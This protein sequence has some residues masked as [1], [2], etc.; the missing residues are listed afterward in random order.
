MSKTGAVD[1]GIKGKRNSAERFSFLGFALFLGITVT[2]WML[3]AQVFGYVV[4]YHRELGSGLLRVGAHTV[5]FPWSW[6]V[7]SFSWSQAEGRLG[8]YVLWLNLGGIISIA[9]GLAAGYFFYYKRSLR[10]E[11]V[12]DLHGSARF[13]TDEDVYAMGLVPKEGTAARGVFVGAFKFLRDGVIRFL[14]YVGD[15]HLLCYAPTRSGKGVTLIIP[16]LL[17]YVHS[18]FTN[19]VKLE[20]FELTSGFRHR[21]GSLVIRFEPTHMPGTSVD[22]TTQGFNTARWNVLDE[23]RIWTPYDVMDAQN[24]AAAIADPDAKGM[25]DHW[26]STSYELLTGLFLHMKYAERNKSLAGCAVYLADPLF[27]TPE[28]MF[29]RMINAEHDPEGRMGWTDSTGRPTKTHPVVA[30]AAQAML[31]KEEKERNSVLST[32]KTRLALFMEPIVGFN[33]SHSDFCINDLMNHEKPVSLYLGVPPSDKERLR[34]LIRLFI[35]FLLR[36]LTADMRFEDG[37]SAAS[38]LNPLLLML[39][40]LSSLRKLDALQDA[41]AYMAGYG[42]RAFM[43]F[44]DRHQMLDEKNGYGKNQ[45]IESGAHIRIAFTPNTLDTA[46]H[47]SKMIGKTTVEHQSVNYSGK[48]MSATMDQMSVTVH[49]VGRALMEP[50]EVMHLPKDETLIFQ[51][52]EPTVRGVKVPYF[53][54]PEFKRRAQLYSPSR[55]GISWRADLTEGAALVQNWLM[56][57]AEREEGGIAIAI[58][59]YR[60]YPP[61]APV[62]KQLDL[63]TGELLS[64]PAQLLDDDGRPWEGPLP[65]D[66]THY[67]LGFEAPPAFDVN[68]SFELHLPLA[69]PVEM[70]EFQQR[71]FLATVS[72][73]EKTMREAVRDLLRDEDVDLSPRFLQL[74]ANAVCRGTVFMV[75][76]HCVAMRRD[77]DAFYIHRRVLLDKEVKEGQEVLIRYRARRGTV[78]MR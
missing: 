58:N 26:V 25:E 8:T 54:V 40:E 47:L 20:N 31:N 52:G 77:E 68:E 11:V 7:W 2:G 38:Y 22:G 71:G 36:R 74:S 46:E 23:I 55:I 6:L 72:V 41:L 49:Q 37:R 67:R 51:A 19:D 39:D 24:I 5:Y 35:T 32:A 59:V 78:E 28:M 10:K 76:E 16:T 14:R 30:T 4:G 42:I 33:T 66:R 12:E 65:E 13:A 29:T 62:V 56:V 15:A 27:A 75:D 43:F 50:D 9:A 45:Q 64:F 48:R 60:E 18:V 61:V 1:L 3:S 69:T 73:H 57:S 17:S 21:A 34:P 63:S 53:T 70:P 44:Q